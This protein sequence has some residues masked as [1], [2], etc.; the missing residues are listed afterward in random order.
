MTDAVD[1]N[2][3]AVVTCDSPDAAWSVIGPVAP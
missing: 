2:D 3:M 1:P